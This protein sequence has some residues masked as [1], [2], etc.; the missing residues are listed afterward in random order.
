MM[1]QAECKSEP[2]QAASAPFSFENAATLA[3]RG[4]VTFAFRPTPFAFIR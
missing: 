4:E 1:H 3:K 2:A